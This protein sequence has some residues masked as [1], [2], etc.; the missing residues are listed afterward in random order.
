M[1]LR[2]AVVGLTGIGTR[3]A[4]GMIGDERVTLVAGCDDG[5]AQNTTLSAD[6][7]SQATAAEVGENFRRN[8]APAYPKLRIYTNHRQMLADEGHI[9]ILTVGVSDHRHADIVVDAANAGVRAIFCEKPLATTLE[10]TDRMLAACER[11]GTLLSVDHTRRFLPIWRYCKEQLVDKGVIGEIQYII[12]RLHGPRSMLWRNG[13]HIIDVLLWFASSKP[14]WVMADAEEGYEDYSFYGQRGVDGG[15]DPALE[16]A[17]NGY[18]CFENGIKG[19]FIGGSKSTPT[20][21]KMEVEVV[22]SKGRLVVDNAGDGRDE[23][24]EWTGVYR[25]SA[26][27]WRGSSKDAET[28]VPSEEYIKRIT[29]PQRAEQRGAWGQESII[30]PSSGRRGT[31]GE[32]VGAPMI[33]IAAGVHDLINQVGSAGAGTVEGPMVSSGRSAQEVVEVL[34]GFVRSAH[35]GSVPVQLPLPRGDQ[36]P[37]AEAQAD[38]AA[39]AIAVNVA[40]AAATAAAAAAQNADVAVAR[41]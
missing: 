23:K 20:N 7:N 29:P 21:I 3:H 35:G 4:L 12:G 13:T 18:I 9:D 2:C 16:P 26:S 27:L 10:D 6:G 17:M 39:T 32:G 8:Y 37:E 15:K 24:G 28:I 11:N 41:L 30:R 38:A 34:A 22:G 40:A 36:R 19:F 5:Y 33:G 25:A 31:D 14:R 1:V